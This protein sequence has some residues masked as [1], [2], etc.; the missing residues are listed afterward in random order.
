MS[1]TSSKTAN[2]K[3]QHG[4]KKPS[5]FFITTSIFLATITTTLLSFISL[6][7]ALLSFGL[8]SLGTLAY[9]EGRRRHFWEAAASFKFKNLH[10]TQDALTK[11]SVVH[12]A[13]IDRLK[14][15]VAHIRSTLDDIKTKPVIMDEPD[16]HKRAAL[17]FQLDT[18]P[19]PT[20]PRATK[21]RTLLS[22]PDLTGYDEDYDAVS[23]TIVRE[24]LHHAIDEKRVDVFVQP[25]V[26][27]PQRQVRFYEMFARIRARPGQYLPASRYMEIAEQDNLDDDID[28]LLLLHCLKT[29]Q[30]SAHIKRAAPFFINIKNSTL[31]NKFFERN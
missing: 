10:E 16:R 12:G 1:K 29:I 5:R 8:F 2:K 22:S 11:D 20:S 13:D 19:L 28:T 23:D 26:R 30:E 9:S 6:E 4:Y 15:D 18:K 27:L 21:P 7:L 31:T 14:D 17:P 3:K 24:L 25:V